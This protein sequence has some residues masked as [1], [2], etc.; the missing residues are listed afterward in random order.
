[1]YIS[2]KLT[3]VIIAVGTASLLLF[4]ACRKLKD[5]EDTGFGT[6]HATLEKTFSD[7]QSI[8][9]MASTDGGLANYKLA[10]TLLG[11]C[12][13]VTKDTIS[14][15]HLMTIDFGATNCLG[16]DGNYRRGKII[17]TY[18]GHYKDPGS[19]HTITFDNDFVND[20][21]VRGA[22]TVTNTG[23]NSSGQPQFSINVNGSVLLSGGNGTISWISSRTRTWISGYTTGDWKDDVYEISGTGTITRVSGRTFDINITTPLHVALDC[24]WIESGIVQITPQ[25]GNIRTLDYGNG[26]CD[27]QANL[28]VNGKTY[29]VSLR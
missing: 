13:T 22:K 20:N 5:T 16:A 25:G 26:T 15:P 27:A 19:S 3:T 11:G 18:T 8:A 9:D 1:M 7:V 24:K 10:P 14:S 4:T 21:E 23:V 6:D 12:A 28:T 2:N 29:S 17:V